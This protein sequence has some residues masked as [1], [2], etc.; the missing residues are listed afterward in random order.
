MSIE[1]KSS[2]KNITINQLLDVIQV[3]GVDQKLE[4]FYEYSKAHPEIGNMNAWD[5]LRSAFRQV[6]CP[7]C[8]GRGLTHS[9]RCTYCAGTGKV[10]F[11][12]T[13]HPM[14]VFYIAKAMRGD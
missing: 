1:L 13:A 9:K 14:N 7:S 11:H 5:F 10:D 4:Q 3:H 6:D 8:I 12:L 2:P